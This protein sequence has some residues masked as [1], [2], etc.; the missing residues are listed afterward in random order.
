M[1]KLILVLAIVSLLVSCDNGNMNNGQNGDYSLIGTWEAEGDYYS[2]GMGENRNYKCT[3]IFH[4]DT[5]Y[6]HIFYWR[7]VGTTDWKNSGESRGMYTRDEENITY[8]NKFHENSGGISIEYTMTR[9]YE[10]TDKNTLV[11]KGPD[12]PIDDNVVYKKKN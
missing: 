6:T 11:T 8:I 4:N 7:G 12:L 9:P 1:K 10:F 5:E 3:L 2:S